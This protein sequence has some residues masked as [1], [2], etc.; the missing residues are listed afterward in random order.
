MGW[1]SGRRYLDTQLVK[2]CGE[3]YAHIFLRWKISTS[4]DMEVRYFSEDPLEVDKVVLLEHPVVPLL[5]GVIIS[6]EV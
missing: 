1:H 3:L 2:S 6:T 5:Q 4:P